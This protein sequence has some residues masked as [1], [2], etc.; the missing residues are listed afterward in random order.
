[1][2]FVTH[3]HGAVG[4]GDD[5]DGYAEAWFLPAANN[6]DPAYAKTGTWYDY[7]KTKA[8]PP[9]ASAWAPGSAT[10]Q[11]PNAQPRIDHLVPRSR[12]RHDEAERVRR[13]CGLLHH[14]RR[15]GW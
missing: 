7:F 2:P 4:V 10:F 5:S 12:A 1:M 13:P 15:S 8:R 14:P 11:Y 3:V 6:I 9:T